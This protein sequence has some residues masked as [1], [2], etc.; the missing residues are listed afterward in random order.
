MTQEQFL[1]YVLNRHGEDVRTECTKMLEH[2]TELTY[3]E[4][5]SV[6]R[7]VVRARGDSPQ[8]AAATMT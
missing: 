5:L 7:M 1:I 2:G 8:M 4:V 6:A 3:E